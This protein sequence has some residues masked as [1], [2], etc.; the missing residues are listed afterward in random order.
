[1]YFVLIFNVNTGV[2]NWYSYID[3]CHAY[4]SK[5]NIFNIFIRLIWLNATDI[6]PI[7]N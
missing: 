7:F 2:Y 5:F 1:M 4:I 6:I 3:Y